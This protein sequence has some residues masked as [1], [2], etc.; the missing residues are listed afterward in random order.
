MYQKDYFKGSLFAAAAQLQASAS[1]AG[2]SGH[3]AAL[4]WI[5]HHSQLSAEHGDGVIL[6]ASSVAQLAQNLDIVEQGPLSDELVQQM[7]AV[8]ELAREAAPKYHM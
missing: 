8:W 3:A 5:L 7:D 1:A 6:G 4:R 2:L